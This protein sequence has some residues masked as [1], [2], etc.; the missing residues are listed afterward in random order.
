MNGLTDNILA[1]A[2]LDLIFDST[3]MKPLFWMVMGGLMVL[4]FSGMRLWF[5]DLGFAMNWW[6]W[7]LFVLWFFGLYVVIS[8][9]FT[10]V[11]EN[12]TRAGMLFLGVFGT[13]FIVLGV[14]LWRLLK[15]K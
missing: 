7:V 11:G 8:G 1:M 6:K 14:G 2:Y 4:F 12:E 3:V 13:L 10:L 5:K 15:R 9:G